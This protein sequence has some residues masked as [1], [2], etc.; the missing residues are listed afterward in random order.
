MSIALVVA[1]AENDVIGRD[2]ELPWHLPDDLRRFKRTTV[3]HVVIMGRRTYESVGAPLPD[4]STI[5]VTRQAAYEVRG[6]TICAGV[7][8]ALTTA[9]EMPNVP[10]GEIL[11]L[12]GESIYREALPRAGRVYLTR[13]HAIVEGDTHFPGLDDHW[14]ITRHEHHPADD[15]HALPFSFQVWERDGVSL[16]PVPTVW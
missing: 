14:H 4:R 15:R 1:A 5:I 12:G 11:V 13:V 3:G 7:D 2:G 9:A 8:A 16:P 6:A 10:R